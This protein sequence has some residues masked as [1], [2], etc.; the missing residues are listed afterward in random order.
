[1]GRV[2]S[3]TSLT[4]VRAYTERMMRSS[5]PPDGIIS[6]S[7]SS[8]IAMMA[9]IEAAG[10]KVGRDIDLVSKQATDILNWIRPEINTANE[11]IRQAGRELAKALMASISGADPAS[12]QS[13]AQPVWPE[14]AS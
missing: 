6:V 1:M 3:E 4:E 7:G 12:L 5:E 13:I 10:K 14:R 2:T 8:S 11:D 9:G